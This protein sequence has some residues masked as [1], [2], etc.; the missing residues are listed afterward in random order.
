[1]TV[2]EDL[3]RR[4]R[5]AARAADTET[6]A[7]A[8]LHVL[9]TVGCV[10]AGSGH[11][12]AAQLGGL[13]RDM[14]DA[15]AMRT[16]ALSGTHPLRTVVWAESVLAHVDEYD[17]LH[18]GA[19][20]APGAVVVPAAQAVAEREGRPGRAV[21]DAVISGYEVVVEAGL[22]F[23]GPRLY[24]RSWWPSATFGAL[25]AAAAVASLLGLDEDDTVAALG[26]A[27][28]GLGGL[29]SGD[30]LGAGHYL[31]LGH[32]AADGT[33]AAHL[34]RAGARASRTLLDGP[35]TAALGTPPEA[36]TAT[37]PHLRDCTFK[38]YPC[39]R[40]LHAALDAL[41]ELAAQGAPLDRTRRV[42]IGLPGPL[43]RFVTAD[44][45][46][47]GP[48]EAAASATFAVA[49]W[50][51]GAATDV[52]FFRGPL[53]PDAPEVLVRH[54]PA[55]DAHL[56]GRWGASVTVEFTDG[57]DPVTYEALDTHRTPS[58]A[59]LTD[60]VVAKFR[61][62]TSTYATRADTDRWVERCLSL[63]TTPPPA[64]CRSCG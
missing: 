62:Q 52:G 33:E 40:P 2:L 55:L 64:S 31:L 1:M 21:V 41:A 35:A 50:L 47:E 46:P 60:T 17:A 29:L 56:P 61:R 39:A 19:A 36:P 42:R 7:L 48:T 25:G 26:I 16:P 63:D 5:R 54:D 24:E 22:R 27:A 10:V 12:L 3:A 23:G 4:G 28:A 58:V 32:A 53:P 20:V 37:G 59:D 45:D 38:R 18:P 14:G 9:D 34:A 44:R 15:G 13:V 8:A 49:A 6:R 30:Q 57:G 51:G 11:P 43:L